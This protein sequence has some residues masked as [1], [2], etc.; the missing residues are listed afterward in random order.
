MCLFFID[1]TLFGLQF[2]L[3][4]IDLPSIILTVNLSVVTH[5]IVL[6]RENLCLKV[7][8][9]GTASVSIKRS[10]LVWLE[11]LM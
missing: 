3:K 1:D 8:K 9:H 2:D 5:V 4:K 11:S 6:S 7:P 10:I